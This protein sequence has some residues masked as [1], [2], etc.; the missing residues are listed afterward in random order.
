M[1]RP[2]Q[3][4][5]TAEDT[6]AEDKNGSNGLP[7]LLIK[8]SVLAIVVSVAGYFI[9]KSAVVI[10]GN[11]GLS[12]SFMGSLFTAVASSLPELI[13][14]IAAVRQG[15]LTL[16][17]GNIIGGN[18][19]DVLFVSFSDFAYADGSIL[20]QVGKSQ[21]FIIVLTLILTSVLTVGLLYREKKGVAKIGWETF[22]MIF[23][24]I[25]G[26]VVLYFLE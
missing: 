11:T 24:F 4:T 9:A 13:V 14:C 12:E 26:Y 17:I 22:T 23:L 6:P 5:A 25:A 8:F 2:R 19:F 21:I 15:A 20:H 1:W 3:T 7:I 18:S 10:A 16:A